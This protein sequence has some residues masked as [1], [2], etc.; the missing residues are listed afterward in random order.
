MNMAHIHDTS[1]SL[2]QSKLLYLMQRTLNDVAAFSYRGPACSQS[3]FIL[4]ES[5]E[6]LVNFCAAFHNLSPSPA[7]MY[8]GR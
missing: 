6:G 7:D 8:G 5:K 1:L 4:K 3:L 2:G